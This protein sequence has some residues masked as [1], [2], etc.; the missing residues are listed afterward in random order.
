MVINLANYAAR[1][2]NYD[3]EYIDWINADKKYDINMNEK[4]SMPYTI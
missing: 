4:K 2:L 1:G 3:I